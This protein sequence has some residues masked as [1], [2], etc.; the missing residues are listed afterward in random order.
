[1]FQKKSFMPGLA[2]VFSAFALPALATDIPVNCTDLNASTVAGGDRFII[3][4]VGADGATISNVGSTHIFVY[5]MHRG[6]HY[7]PGERIFIQ[8]Y[9]TASIQ[10]HSS[11]STV[12]CRLGQTF[13]EELSGDTAGIIGGEAQAR[14]ASDAVSKA[15]DVRKGAANSVTRNNL[16]FST[17]NTPGQ[18]SAGS[19]WSAW[20][21]TDIRGYSSGSTGNGFDFLFGADKAISENTIAGVILGYSKLDLT[22]ATVKTTS[23]GPAL[24]A[25]IASDLGN[26]LTFDAFVLASRPKYQVG[27]GRFTANRRAGGL[28]LRGEVSAGQV[29]IA[30]VAKIY[31]FTENQPSYTF[32]GGT[33]AAN[34][35]TSLTGHLGARFS[36]TVAMKGF[37]PYL[38]LG[39]DFSRRT[40]TQSGRESFTSP[41]IGLG[42]VAEL[43]QG[44]LAVDLTGGHAT[45]GVRDLGG[46]ITYTINF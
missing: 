46:S 36:P 11:G 17:K 26:G 32:S 31:G 34:R 24:G 23:S 42:F 39:A 18:Y 5:T 19:D 4:R 14:A 9:Q 30:P 3:N 41:R 43:G 37:S 12:S 21:S 44:T 10:P 20:V 25:Y 40:S 28:S 22:T 38:S 35:I 15:F 27:T 1:M 7:Q 2:A 29:K 6:T 45:K 8:P 13:D 16:F 33:V